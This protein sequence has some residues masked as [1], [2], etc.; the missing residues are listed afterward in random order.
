MKA[1]FTYFKFLVLIC[2]LFSACVPEHEYTPLLSGHWEGTFTGSYYYKG[3]DY[4]YE[5][6]PD[7]VI[8]S[9]SRT[10]RMYT[11]YD[12]KEVKYSD[13]ELIYDPNSDE[14]QFKDYFYFSNF[15]DLQAGSMQGFYNRTSNAINGTFTASVLVASGTS[16]IEVPVQGNFS[17][18][19]I[20]S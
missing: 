14:V 8:Y 4:L 5:D 17:M 16:Y 7:F 19:W 10:Y 2:T 12:N 6:Y 9:S 3:K 18:Q 13:T 20:G 1:A 15:K 11:V